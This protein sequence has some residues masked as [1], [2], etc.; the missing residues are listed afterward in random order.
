MV[1]HGH[2]YS[3][4]LTLWHLELERITI[5]K[6]TQTQTDHWW[7]QDKQPQLHFCIP[8]CVLLSQPIQGK[9]IHLL[10]QGIVVEHFESFRLGK[11]FLLFSSLPFPSSQMES[12]G[13]CCPFFRGNRSETE[14]GSGVSHLRH[15]AVRKSGGLFWICHIASTLPF[16]EEPTWSKTGYKEV[17]LPV[18]TYS[19]L[20]PFQNWKVKTE[21][22]E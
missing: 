17:L 18:L 7:N 22:L 20:L 9:I 13:S 8:Y 10:W 4:P 19:S 3:S 11:A 1:W 15:T 6:I 2:L 16:W 12:Y 14:V 5:V 21:H